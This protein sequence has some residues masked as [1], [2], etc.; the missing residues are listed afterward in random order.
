MFLAI[1]GHRQRLVDELI[2]ASAGWRNN[3]SLRSTEVFCQ[4]QQQ[5]RALGISLQM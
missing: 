1:S 2:V 5:Q 4:Q 3:Q